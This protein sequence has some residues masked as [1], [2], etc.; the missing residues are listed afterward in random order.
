MERCEQAFRTGSEDIPVP[1]LNFQLR[2]ACNQALW[3]ALARVGL[4]FQT[5]ELTHGLLR[6]LQ[7]PDSERR[8]L[9]GED[10]LADVQVDEVSLAT[11]SDP[12]VRF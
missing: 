9:A 1:G 12:Q 11:A 5:Y 7:T 2:G 10:I 6:V 3:S 8:W 4:S